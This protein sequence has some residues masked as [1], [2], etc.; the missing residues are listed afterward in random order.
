MD[1]AGVRVCH[2]TSMSYMKILQI[3]KYRV[4]AHNVETSFVS[5]P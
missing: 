1:L 2:F 5:F 4:T 3:M